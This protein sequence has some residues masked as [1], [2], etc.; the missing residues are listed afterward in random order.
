MRNSYGN[1]AE[2]WLAGWQ[3]FLNLAQAAATRAQSAANPAEAFAAAVQGSLAPDLTAGVP[4]VATPPGWS[5]GAADWSTIA[6]LQW[7]VQETQLRMAQHWS[8]V[9]RR[10]SVQFAERAGQSSGAQAGHGAAPTLRELY[11]LWIDCAEDAYATEVHSD[12]YCRSFAE[13]TNA[14]QA[15]RAAQRKMIDAWAE[16]LDLPTRG[17]WDTLVNRV[18]ELEAALARATRK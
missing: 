2:D 8:E 13:H 18:S 15:L 11:D 1:G 10:A 9:L 14:T 7:R 5:Q 3:Q 17:D 6:S 4:P 12:D 16:H